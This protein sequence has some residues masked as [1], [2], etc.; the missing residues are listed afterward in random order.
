MHNPYYCTWSG[1]RNQLHNGRSLRIVPA[2]VGGAD[3]LWGYHIS[4]VQYRFDVSSSVPTD[5]APRQSGL[6]GGDLGETWRQLWSTG[7]TGRPGVSPSHRQLC[8]RRGWTLRNAP[9]A[10]ATDKRLKEFETA[11]RFPDSRGSLISPTIP[12]AAGRLHWPSKRGALEGQYS[13]GRKE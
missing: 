9:I 4:M 5:L 8:Q 1:G 7:P 3:L 11:T 2:G 12:D 10:C 13:E 6:G